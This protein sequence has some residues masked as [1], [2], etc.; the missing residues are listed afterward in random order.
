M[1]KVKTSRGWML[2]DPLPRW[3][4]LTADGHVLSADM[5]ERDSK[6]VHSV[7]DA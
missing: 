1:T 4:G 3:I 6:L 5:L 2:I 7:W